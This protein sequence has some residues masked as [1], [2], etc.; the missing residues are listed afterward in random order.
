MTHTVI[1]SPNQV[2]PQTTIKL[3]TNSDIDAMSRIS[4]DKCVGSYHHIENNHNQL[5]VQQIPRCNKRKQ[6]SPR[7]VPLFNIT[8]WTDMDL[9]MD[10]EEYNHAEEKTGMFFF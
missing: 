8:N 7:R 3:E 5:D 2:L 1:V 4:F 10:V 9:K 6:S